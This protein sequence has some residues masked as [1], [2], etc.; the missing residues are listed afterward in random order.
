MCRRAMGVGLSPHP[1]H[2]Q[3]TPAGVRKPAGSNGENTKVCTVLKRNIKAFEHP[4]FPPESSG[5]HSPSPPLRS[6]LHRLGRLV[7]DQTQEGTLGTQGR[8]G[9]SLATAAPGL[10]QRSPARD[11]GEPAAGNPPPPPPPP[12]GRL[13]QPKALPVGEAKPAVMTEG[14]KRQQIKINEAEAAISGSS[15]WQS[16]RQGRGQAGK[17]GPDPGGPDPRLSQPRAL[18]AGLSRGDPDLGGKLVS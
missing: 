5:P 4:D 9:M 18:R 8:T 7:K 17:G 13:W 6:C 14:R 15:R 1:R 3:I 2:Q 16:T 12:R 10:A 11:F